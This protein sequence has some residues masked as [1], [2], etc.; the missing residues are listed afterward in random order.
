[1]STTVDIFI[2]L[3]RSVVTVTSEEISLSDT[4]FESLYSLAKFHD[5]AHLV[6]YELMQR[7]ALGEGEM[8]RKFKAQYEMALFR[9]VKRDITINNIRNLFEEKKIPFVFLKGVVLMDLYPE[10]W[11]RTSSDIDVLVREEDLLNAENAFLSAGMKREQKGEYDISFTS[12]ENFHIELHYSMLEDYTSEKVS[13]VMKKAWDYFLPK[14]ACSSE[15]IMQDEMF[16][17]YHIAHMA[18]H[19]R[20]GGNGVRTI[21]DL[22][23]LNHSLS[24]NQ[25]KRYEL[26]EE[27]GLRT[28]DDNARALS[29]KWFSNKENIALLHDFEDYIICGGIFGTSERNITIK[30]LKVGN[31]FVYYIRRV[32][33]PYSKIKYTF[34]ILQ[35]APFLLPG[36]WAIRWFK[37]IDPSVRKRT[38]SEIKVE[39]IANKSKNI[40]ENI[41]IEHLMEQL[42]IW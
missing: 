18:K 2:A 10:P 20:N 24:F 15:R 1:M 23:L 21:I 17:F 42:K 16:Y 6:Y 27:G 19:F 31:R 5:L 29:E 35:K 4:N 28:F 38:A 13:R 12:K 3:L 26:L 36:A 14:E 39:R 11:M 32:F 8:F 33:L 41:R 22:W 7:N 9:H 40:T 34:P 37:L 30:K 25:S